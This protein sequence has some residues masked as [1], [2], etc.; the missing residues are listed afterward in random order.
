MMQ[1]FVFIFRQG[2]R[3]LSEEEQ[4]RRTEDVRDWATKHVSDGH[5]LD[6]R[7]LD[8]ASDH[9]GDDAAQV[10]HD[11]TVIALNFIAAEDFDDAV[12]IA[13]THPGLRYGVNI[14]VRPW[15]DPRASVSS[16]R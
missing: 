7:V 6:P 12:R 9:L 2:S 14:E 15:K 5:G 1:S 16:P 3:T 4:K 13:K 10:D 8:N 11:R